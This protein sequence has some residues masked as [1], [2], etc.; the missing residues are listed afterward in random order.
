MDAVMTN[1][2]KL[3]RLAE[4]AAGE[5]AL[6]TVHLFTNDVDPGPDA[7]V[8]D[9]NEATFAGYAA[10]ALGAFGDPFMG[11]DGIA[12]VY[13]PSQQYNWTGAPTETVYGFYI[14]SAG[15]GT[16]FIEYF[17]LDTPKTMQ[18]ASD[19]LRLDIGV[20]ESGATVGEAESIG[21]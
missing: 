14:L 10:Q 18:S 1:A 11:P 3:R 7:V 12:R 5:I 8:G 16:P 19:A 2:A 15:G 21:Q 13:A 20:L 9:F 6:A 17:R 4:V